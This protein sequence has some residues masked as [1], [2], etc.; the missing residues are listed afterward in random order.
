MA[1]RPGK[2]EEPPPAPLGHAAL[3]ARQRAMRAA[4][5]LSSDLDLRLHRA[6][7]WLGRAEAEADDPDLRFILLWI[8]FNAIYAADIGREEVPQREAFRASFQRLV[9][10]DGAGRIYDRLWT[11]FP[12]EIR[13]L[14]AN[15][16]LWPGFWRFHNGDPAHAGW[17]TALAAD[18]AAVRRAL[19]R[20]DTVDILARLFERLYVLRNQLVHG[21][22]TWASSVNRAQVRD[23]AA[24]LGQLVPLFLEIM[25][26]HPDE[27]WGRPWYP[28]VGA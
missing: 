7:S 25:M 22:A 1:R 19:A 2:P 10:L 14:L 18:V 20:R 5:G 15:R 12:A 16:F 9:R 27:D 23:G 21:G 3:K 26:D 17:E 6:L 8:A 4:A 28:V 24:L 13:T 11:R